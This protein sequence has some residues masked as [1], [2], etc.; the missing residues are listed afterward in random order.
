MM[1]SPKTLASRLEQKLLDIF[2]VN[3]KV[4]I[5]EFQKQDDDDLKFLAN[6]VYEKIFLHYTT[7]Q[8]GVSLKKSMEL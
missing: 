1:F 8:W 2:E 6:Y 7:K 4:P 5:L 3:S